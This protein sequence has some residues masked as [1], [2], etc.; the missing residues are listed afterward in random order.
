M[1]LGCAFSILAGVLSAG[2]PRVAPETI[3]LHSTFDAKEFSDPESVLWPGYFWLWNTELDPEVIKAQLRDMASHGARSVC[4]LPM[5]H[6]FRPDTTNNSLNPDYLTP[7]FFDRVRV[8]VETAAELGMNWWLYDEGGWPSGSALG[9]VAEGHP[10]FRQQRLMAEAI[11]ALGAYVVPDDALALIVEKP[12]HKT[13]RP[14][15]HWDPPVG[16]EPAML[17]SVKAGGYVDLLN[18][19][20]TRRFIEL[21]HEQ[22]RKAVGAHFGKT[23]KFTFTDEPNA[24]NLDPP[25]SITWTPGM[26]AIYRERT[27]G[28]LMDVLPLLFSAPGVSAAPEVAR[29]RMGFYDAWTQRFR[30]AYFEPLRDWAEPLGLGSGGHLNGEDETINAVRYGFGEALR[31][32]RAMDVPGVDL[33]WRQLFPGRKGQHF[34]PKYASSAAHQNG[35]RYAFTES[36][37][38]YGNGL[39]P[40]QMRQLVNYQY[41][42]GLNLLVVGCY[43][44]STRDHHMTGERPHFG[45]ANPHWDQLEGFHEYT[46]RLGYALSSGKPKISTALY[47]PARDM[48]ALGLEAKEAVETHDKLAAALFAAQR[49]FDLIDDDMLM[50]DASRVEGSELVAGA[51]RYST[52]ICGKVCWMNPAALERLKEFTRAGGRV[53]AFDFAPGSDGA[54]GVESDGTV[55][56]DDV[57]AIAERADATVEISP[58]N[59]DIRAAGRIVD[60]GEILTLFNEGGAPYDGEICLSSNTINRLDLSRGRVFKTGKNIRIEPGEML[61]FSTVPDASA[62][63]PLK[64]S[65]ETMDLTAKVVAEPRRR[66]VVG[67][68]DFES[69]EPSVGGPWWGE[70]GGGKVAF[71]KASVWSAWLS[72]DYSGEVEYSFSVDIPEEWSG[73]GVRLET[74][75]IEYAATVYVDGAKAGEMLWA[76]WSLELPNC[77]PG[78]HKVEI[79]VANTLANELTSER[80][81]K[82][83]ADKSGPGW[84]SPY[85]KRAL[86]FE[87]ESRGG[88]IKGPII[89]RRMTPAP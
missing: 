29:S 87:V 33:I 86:V 3:A 12:E 15:D 59:A 49:D 67:E 69:L 39:T 88:G 50:G 89:A 45:A 8:G 47:Y 22:Y 13:L 30:T 81:S 78:L 17:Y 85:H 40:E 38:V 42:R 43:P 2:T 72:P 51:M 77:G 1:I 66:T 74:G 55:V 20:V 25:K 19:D 68:H 14:G 32:L 82:L 36:F 56:L 79:R 75:P 52:I 44:M 11:P 24:P 71:E 5:P 35:T 48:W 65:D 80:V 73:S 31:Q 76:P 6:G 58:A 34:F 21:T 41:I 28:E 84:P 60:G 54:P 63:A 61:A 7:E 37:C 16:G 57:R 83:W 26:D 62:E 53:L 9:K 64:P 23:I 10:E 70:Y 18:P 4:M 46:A 27:G